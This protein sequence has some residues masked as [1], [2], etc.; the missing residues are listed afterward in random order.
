MFCG[1]PVNSII[2]HKA[3]KDT[4]AEPFFTVQKQRFII[5]TIAHFWVTVFSRSMTWSQR[6]R[7]WMENFSRNRSWKRC[8]CRLTLCWLLCLAPNT[9]CPWTWEPTWGRLKRRWK[10]RWVKMLNFSFWWIHYQ[11][12]TENT[13]TAFCF[14]WRKCVC[15]FCL[16]FSLRRSKQV[17]GGRTS[18]TRPGWMAGRRCSRQR[19]K[20]AFI[21]NR[22][23]HFCEKYESRWIGDST[24]GRINVVWC[25]CMCF[26]EMNC[27]PKHTCFKKDSKTSC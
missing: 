15:C 16:C 25:F 1:F 26:V 27:C 24:N 9:K 19:P 20:S 10:R 7:T 5:D 3:L 22:T 11:L 8:G 14:K 23:T 13:I 17:T 12:Q 2:Y 21:I 4:E 6:F 18:K